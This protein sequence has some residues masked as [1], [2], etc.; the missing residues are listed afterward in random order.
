[1][2]LRYND[3]ENNDL[4]LSLSLGSSVL[5]GGR[6]GDPLY[7]MRGENNMG[8][9]CG[10]TAPRDQLGKFDFTKSRSRSIFWCKHCGR[11]YDV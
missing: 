9:T 2:L 7:W 4:K 8:P 1:M 5:C 3:L 11:W 6:H 10:R